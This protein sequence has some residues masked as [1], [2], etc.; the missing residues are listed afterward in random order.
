MFLLLLNCLGHCSQL[1]YSS[2]DSTHHALFRPWWVPFSPDENTHAIPSLFIS[3]FC[4]PKLILH[5][6]SSISVLF[7]PAKL[8]FKLFFLG[9]MYSSTQSLL[10]FI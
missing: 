6:C 8:V 4:F 10:V 9:Y 1:D 3:I 2:D 5:A 7:M